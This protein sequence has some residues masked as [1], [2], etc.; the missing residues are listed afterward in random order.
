MFLSYTVQTDRG[1][2]E[3]LNSLNSSILLLYPRIS[4]T[5]TI[6]KPNLRCSMHREM[7]HRII[8]VKT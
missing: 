5:S 1:P 3:S 2:L 4:Y 6:G 8:T 7:S